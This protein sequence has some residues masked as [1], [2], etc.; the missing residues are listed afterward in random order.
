[1]ADEKYGLDGLVVPVARK[2]PR[3]FVPEW[4]RGLL[5]QLGDSPC[6]MC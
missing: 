2:N 3:F 1:M 5:N 4:C 6:A